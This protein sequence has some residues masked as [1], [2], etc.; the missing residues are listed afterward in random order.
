MKIAVVG[1]TGLTGGAVTELALSKGYEVVAV[2]R[3]PRKIHPAERLTAVEGN[4]MDA[5]S[6]VA[7]F[8]GVDAVISCFGPTGGRNPVTLMSEGTA[9]IT[10]ACAKAD[11]RKLVMM[12]GILQ[13]DGKELSL[14]NRF[15]IK[16]IRL[17]YYRIYRD[18]IIAEK[19]LQNSGLD[20]V[21]VRPAGLS[22]TQG[23]GDYRAGYKARISPFKPL[24]YMDCAA[25][26]LRTIT[27]KEWNKKIIH[28]GKL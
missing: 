9:N 13:S 23:D 24:S 27:K 4:V 20:W 16:I 5:T 18:K 17:F 19:T 12:S 6:L 11:V 10:A 28:V 21:I 1:A 3:N 7:A 14:I 8:K 15:L 22:K 25:F 26:L 2:A